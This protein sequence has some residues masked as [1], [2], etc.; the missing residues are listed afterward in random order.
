M[1]RAKFLEIADLAGR[2]DERGYPHSSRDSGL[3]P[4]SAQTFEF[5]L[6]N[7]ANQQVE[8][9][10]PVFLFCPVSRL[11]SSDGHDV[12]QPGATKPLPHPVVNFLD[13]DRVQLPLGDGLAIKSDSRGVGHFVGQ[14]HDIRSE[15][16][17][18]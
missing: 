16:S 11:G 8:V 17:S 12:V 3:R 5:R 1:E 15:P 6:L 4:S 18:K 2:I 13:I 14:R 10:E 9:D 7:I